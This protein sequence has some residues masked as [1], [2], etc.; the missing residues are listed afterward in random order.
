MMNIT[1][2]P[3]FIMNFGIPGSG[4]STYTRRNNPN[5]LVVSPDSIRKEMFGNISNQKN[6]SL[7][8]ARAIGR[9]EGALLSKKGV[10]LDAVNLEKE[11]WIDMVSS[12]PKCYKIAWVFNVHPALAFDRI[13]RDLFLRKDRCNVPREVVFE[14]YKLFED[15]VSILPQYFDKVIMI[16]S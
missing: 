7:V 5:K 16:N 10:I 12:L 1:N 6:N 4:K 3:K 14:Y 13:Q 2:L 9:V 15:T 8:W 11:K